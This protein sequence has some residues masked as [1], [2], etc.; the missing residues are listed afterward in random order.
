MSDGSSR[1]GRVLKAAQAAQSGRHVLE[2]PVYDARLEAERILAEARAEAE[3]VVAEAQAEAE[4]LRAQAQAEGRERGLQAV[5]ELL[6]GARAVAARAR[7]EAAAELRA[8]AVHIAEKILGRQLALAPELVVDVAAE[9]L[10]HA[11]E[12]RELVIRAHPDD[13]EALER[14]KPRLLE[15]CRRSAIVVRGDARIARGGCVVESDLGAVDARLSTQ[16]EA[17]E[18]ALKGEA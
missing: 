10:R 15:R 5:T 3:R 12:P 7:T 6:A 2:A 4:R 9:A 17:I 8:L 14:G 11:G 13:V 18:R 16:L 1:T